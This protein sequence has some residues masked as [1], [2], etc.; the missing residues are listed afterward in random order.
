VR[1]VIGIGAGLLVA[2]L[3]MLLALAV[4]RPQG[5][6]LTDAVRLLPD[7][8]GLVRRLAGDGSLPRSTR[9]VLGLLVAY[10]VFPIDVVPDFIPVLGYADDAIVVALALRRVVRVAGGAAV[11]RHWRGSEAGLAIVRRL[12]GL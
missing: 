9:L 10:L 1:L 6:T 8:I 2:W 7:L 5:A 3:A 12:A 4:A 11:E